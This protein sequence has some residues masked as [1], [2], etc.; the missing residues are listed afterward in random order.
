MTTSRAYKPA[1]FRRR[2]YSRRAA[3]GSLVRNGSVHLLIV[4]RADAAGILDA[5]RFTRATSFLLPRVDQRLISPIL[6]RVTEAEEEAPVVS[7][8]EH[9]WLQLKNQLLRDLAAGGSQI[10]PVQLAIG[11]DC[12]ASASSPRPSMRRTAECAA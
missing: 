7:D 6:D 4:C 2:S 8:P 12:G 5:L 9:G 10:L 1:G 3:I 11:L